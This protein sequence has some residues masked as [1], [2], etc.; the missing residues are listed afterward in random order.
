MAKSGLTRTQVQ[1]Q[2]NQSIQQQVRQEV[3][4]VQ[5]AY[6]GPLPPPEILEQFGRIVPNG[7]ER[8]FAQFESQAEHRQGL[9]SRVIRSNT[10]NQ[11][12]GVVSAS[13][14][15]LIGVCGGLLLAYLGKDLAGLATTFG[16]LGSL[17]G[18]FIYGKHS[19]SSQLKSK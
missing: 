12:I 9:E 7:A 17:V 10:L 1:Q 2:I 11:T 18:V 19:Q 15:G 14:I 5:I 4:G 3:T 8:I 16:T 13:L 6:S